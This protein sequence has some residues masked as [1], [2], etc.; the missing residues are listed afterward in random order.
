MQPARLMEHLYARCVRNAQRESCVNRWKPFCVR[1]FFFL[2]QT[3]VAGAC[4]SVYI[5]HWKCC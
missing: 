2:L 1:G 3:H 5:I 4:D